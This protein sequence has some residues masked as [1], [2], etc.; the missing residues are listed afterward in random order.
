MQV[1]FTVRNSG[2]TITETSWTDAVYLDRV[3][4]PGGTLPSPTSLPVAEVQRIGTLQNGGSYTLE[5]TFRIP[6]NWEGGLTVFLLV[7]SGHII[8]DLTGPGQSQAVSNISDVVMVTPLKFPDLSLT[9]SNANISLSS[10]EP[11]NLE[12]NI[13]NIGQGSNLFP[14]FD[15]IYLSEDAIV[16]PFDFK[17]KSPIHN[18]VLN[19]GQMKTV[20]EEVDIPFDITTTSLYF[21]VQVSI[22]TLKKPILIRDASLASSDLSFFINGLKQPN[23]PC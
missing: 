11:Y 4:T 12:Y 17:L 16:D 6:A 14:W 1:R 13:T 23:W 15:T 3:V 5:A 18:D 22:N 7:D 21:I 2:G 19:P 9:F 10:G 8:P 20:M